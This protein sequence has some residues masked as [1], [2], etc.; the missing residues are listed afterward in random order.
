MSC[1][2]LDSSN[3]FQDD[4]TKKEVNALRSVIRCIE[5]YN[6]GSQYSPDTLRK[7]IDWLIN[8]KKENK[9]TNKDATTK[10]PGSKSQ[11]QRLAGKKRA[12]SD[13]KNQSNNQNRKKNPR[14][15]WTVPTAT[16]LN[17]S[18][19][20]VAAGHHHLM[21]HRSPHQ[22]VALY[23]RQA[24]RYLIPSSE[25][26]APAPADPN[27]YGAASNFS[28]VEASHHQPAGSYIDQGAQCSAGQYSLAHSIPDTYRNLSSGTYG[29]G[30][31]HT[32]HVKLT[33][34]AY[35]LGGSTVPPHG[36]LTS[37]AYR[38]A[39]SI[40]VNH[41]IS[42]TASHYELVGSGSVKQHVNSL[43]ERYEPSIDAS[44]RQHGSSGLPTSMGVASDAAS[45]A[46]HPM[47]RLRISSYNDRPAPPSGYN[48][49]PNHYHTVYRL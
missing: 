35:G 34:A 2:T 6:L 22:P 46:Y 32:Q 11:S 23:E 13:S 36:S 27:T 37:G 5:S 4:T 16:A 44:G 45:L 33:S 19:G 40:P 30:G 21:H 15:A 25:M 24:T 9:T 8:Q 38:L 12:A 49:L 10:T 28:T 42:P 7:R 26:V 29:S 41:Q 3:P 43:V 18:L 14:T 1:F 39:G 17:H 31:S 48:A 20:A 47:D